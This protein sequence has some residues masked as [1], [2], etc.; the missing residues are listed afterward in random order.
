LGSLMI[1]IVPALVSKY[2]LFSK[3]VI[4][5]VTVNLGDEAWASEYEANR[6]SRK[7]MQDLILQFPS[8]MPC[9]RLCC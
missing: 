1:T 8:A 6:D 7:S 5:P 9:A 4:L 3:I 2:K